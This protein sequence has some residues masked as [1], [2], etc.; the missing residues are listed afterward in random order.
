MKV[1]HSRIFQRAEMFQ[2]NK[3]EI[4]AGIAISAAMVYS[5]FGFQMSGVKMYRSPDFFDNHTVNRHSHD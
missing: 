5:L 3:Y 4:K 1:Q 2:Q